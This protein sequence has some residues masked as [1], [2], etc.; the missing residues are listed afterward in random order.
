MFDLAVQC[1]VR[2]ASHQ[3]FW[4]GIRNYVVVRNHVPKA[5]GV[6]TPWS[7]FLR[8]S[9][10]KYFCPANAANLMA[11]FAAAFYD[12]A[13]VFRCTQITNKNT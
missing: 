13:T 3:Y 2:I 7:F 12:H 1:G 10:C 11:L 8:V 9:G 6:S 5:A 4:S